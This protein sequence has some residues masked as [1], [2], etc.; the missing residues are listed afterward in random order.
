MI[1]NNERIAAASMIARHINA[2]L[3][4]DPNF[5]LSGSQLINRID[6][7]CD[8]PATEPCDLLAIRI[9]LLNDPCI[10]IR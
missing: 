5:T 7:Y 10:P 1:T 8:D 4:N 6:A 3:D 9:M 2:D